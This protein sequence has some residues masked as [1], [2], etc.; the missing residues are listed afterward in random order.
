M[1]F[2]GHTLSWV[3]CEVNIVA[4]IL[5]PRFPSCSWI[6]ETSVGFLGALY[7]VIETLQSCINT[8]VYL[9]LYQKENVYGHVFDLMELCCVAMVTV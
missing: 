1:K 7:S 9:L 5:H 3:S 2:I 4:S 6:R 8:F